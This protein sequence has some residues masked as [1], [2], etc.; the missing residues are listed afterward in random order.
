MK[1][2]KTSFHEKKQLRFDFSI[3]IGEIIKLCRLAIQSWDK[4]ILDKEWIE[5]K[6]LIEIFDMKRNSIFI[7][8]RFRSGRVQSLT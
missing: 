2:A 6:Y 3:E 7:G 4:N 1:W 8:Y 5:S